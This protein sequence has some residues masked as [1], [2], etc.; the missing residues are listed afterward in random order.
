MVRVGCAGIL[1]ADT[2][3]GPV[4]AL[5]QPG[6]CSR[7]TTFRLRREGAL[8]M[9]RS[10]SPASAS[11]LRLRAASVTTP[12]PRRRSPRCGRMGSTARASSSPIVSRPARPSSCL[13]PGEDRRFIH[14]FGANA[15]F[16][17]GHI[18][19]EWLSGL[20]VFYLG[21]L[22]V[23]PGSRSTSSSTFS[24]SA[25]V[26][27][28]HRRHRGRSQAVRP[29]SRPRKAPADDRLFPAERR[30]GADFHRPAR[31][32]RSGRRAGRSRRADSDRHLRGERRSRRAGAASVGVAAPSIWPI[33]DPQDAA[34]PLLRA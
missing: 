34:T 3:C 20:S 6:N 11:P 33:V 32:C 10:M 2:L 7:S 29:A 18:R 30:R 25:V 14:A 5:P 28:R 9:S 24:P 1:V 21:G 26:G 22:F 13:S 31:P 16:N 4:E 15:E 27:H 23:M 19:R 12:P 8:R 17:I